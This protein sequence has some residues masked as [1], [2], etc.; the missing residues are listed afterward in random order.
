VIGKHNLSPDSHLRQLCIHLGQARRAVE[1]RTADD[2]N[3]IPAE[4]VDNVGN[5]R[6]LTSIAGTHA[7]KSRKLFLE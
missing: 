7:Q 4:T 2:G 5:G 1:I 3:A 6:T